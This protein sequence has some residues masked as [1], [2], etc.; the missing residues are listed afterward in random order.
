MKQLVIQRRVGRE[1]SRWTRWTWRRAESRDP[2]IREVASVTR[3]GA[4]D[5]VHCQGV[6]SLRETRRWRE[7][8]YVARLNR[9]AERKP[10]K[11]WLKL[12]AGLRKGLLLTSN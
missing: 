2:A 10:A 1:V 6:S 9:E 3:S 12:C 8:E 5:R 7:A 4:S 11:L